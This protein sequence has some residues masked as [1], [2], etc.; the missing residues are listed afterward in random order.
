[1]KDDRA[2]RTYAAALFSTT[3]QD[4]LG[5]LKAVQRRL[6]A[7]GDDAL[8]TLDDPDVPFAQKEKAL[9]K[10]LPKKS[11]AGVGNFIRVLAR[12]SRVATLPGI[13][14]ELEA[15]GRWGPEVRIAHVT[16]SVPLTKEEIAA[17]KKIL[18]TRWGEKLDFRFHVN[19]TLLGGVVVR[20]GDKVIDGSVEGRLRNLHRR[21]RGQQ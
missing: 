1:M 2:A 12:E 17:I 21:L 9:R 20:M 19:P 8:N 10:I 7:V 15:L 4:W 11:P 14:T 13:I 5:A 16:S 3:T 6:E 18:I